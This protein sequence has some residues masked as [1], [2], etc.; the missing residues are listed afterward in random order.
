MLSVER[1][2]PNQGVARAPSTGLRLV[3]TSRVG[4]VEIS[5]ASKRAPVDARLA[6]P[7]SASTDAADPN[8]RTTDRRETAPA[9]HVTL[10]MIT[11]IPRPWQCTPP[12][13]Q[14]A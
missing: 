10:R 8:P 2:G 3:A 4:L 5:E 7:A 11:E 6:Q 12:I 13:P 14:L 9:G 1:S